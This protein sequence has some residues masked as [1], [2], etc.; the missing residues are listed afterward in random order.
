M[1]CLLT[2]SELVTLLEAPRLTIPYAKEGLT[3]CPFA[4]SLALWGELFQ[5]FLGTNQTSARLYDPAAQRESTQIQ[6]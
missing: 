6:N 1:T 5:S 3:D 4:C 2:T